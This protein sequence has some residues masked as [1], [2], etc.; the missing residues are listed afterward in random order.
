M[1]H[2]T[3]CEGARRPRTGNRGVKSLAERDANDAIAR[4]AEH[5]RTP[6][7]GGAYALILS[8]VAT[9][10]LGI[11]YWTLA[12]R[13][14]DPAQVGVNAAAISTMTFLSYLTQLNLAG[15]LSRFIPTA[16]RSTSRLVGAAYLLVVV[17]S[18]FAAFVFLAGLGLWAPQEHGLASDPLVAL[19][20]VVATMGWSLFALQDGVLTG[21]RQTVWVPIENT[22]FAVAKIVLLAAFALSL[23]EYGIFASWTIPAV[24][25]IIPVNLLI[26]RRFIPRHQSVERP[27][28][29]EVA[30]RRMLQYLTGDYLG[31]LAISA[32][33]ALLPLLVLIK[34]GPS[35]SAYFYIAWTI[36]YSLQL[37]SI[38]VATSLMVEG[39]AQRDSVAH[40]ARRML[41]LLIRL[42]V[43]IVAGVL[44][45]TPV[46]LRFFGAAYASEGEG[47]LRLLALAVLPHGVNAIYLSLARVRRRASRVAMVQ[48]TVSGLTLVLS[49]ILLGPM[50][51][52]GVGIAWLVAQSA[53]AAFLLATQLRPIWRGTGSTPSPAAAVGGDALP[54]QEG[55]AAGDAATDG[56]VVTQARREPPPALLRSAFAAFDAAGIGWTV[57]RGEEQLGS[58]G[59][60]IDLLVDAARS[61]EID[62]EL[63]RLGFVRLPSFGRGTHR[64]YIALEVESGHWTSLDLVSELAYGRL[65]ELAVPTAA[66]CLDR[67]HRPADV[68]VLEAGD[69][70]WT[71]LLH[72]ILDK[73]AVSE[74]RARRLFELER[75]ISEDSPTGRFAA[76]LLPAG[77]DSGRVRAAVRARDWPALLDLRGPL[78][79]A[80]L[81]RAPEDVLLRSV[82]GLALRV[83][84]PILKLRRRGLSVAV[85]GPDGAGKSTLAAGIKETFGLPVRLIYMGLWKTSDRHVSSWWRPL[86]IGLRPLAVWR[87]YLVAQTHRA[88]GRIVIFD[89]YTYDAFIPP[90][91]RFQGLKR[92]YF[93]ILARMIPE[94]DLVIV[95]DAPGVALFERKGESDP[96]S[97]E[98]D[99]AQFLALR[100]RVRRLEVIDARASADVVLSDA[101]QRIWD[102]YREVCG[103]RATI[104]AGSAT[105]ARSIAIAD[106]SSER[107]EQR[108]LRPIAGARRRLQRRTYGARGTR[109]VPAIL[110]HLRDQELV[111]DRP[112]RIGR[113][114]STETGVALITVTV[115][116]APSFLLKVPQ[117]ADA[118]RALVG[119]HELV[120]QLRGD[121]RLAGW[122]DLIPLVTAA[123]EVEGNAFL[124]EEM[125][126]GVAGTT[127]LGSGTARATMLL[128]AASAIRQLHRRTGEV[129]VVDDVLLESWVRKPLAAVERVLVDRFRAQGAGL[130]L[131]ELGRELEDQLAGQEVFTSWVHGDFWPG[132]VLLQPDGGKVTGIVDWDLAAPHQLPL[133][134][135]LHLILY[136]RR[137][138]YGRE[139]GDVVRAAIDDPRWDAT[140]RRLIDEQTDDTPGPQLSDRSAILLAWLRHVS[141]FSSV[142]GH[143]A[144][145]VWIRNNIETIIRTP[146]PMR[147]YG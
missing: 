119:H 146:R 44:I 41:S 73:R 97:L 122:S 111:E 133:H 88:L 24:L 40:D 131:A 89:R 72:S 28:E 56:S 63:V 33:T 113:V 84:E 30:P 132:N 2:G 4:L 32:S 55:S 102:T 17:L 87:R 143:G 57:L 21:L 123:G 46:V 137:V 54:V 107:V 100:N 16:G 74:A 108:I 22:I 51:I 69:E 34:V 112:W 83:M 3:P 90:S 7:Y 1:A 94:P 147:G 144:N 11:V 47:L 31:S 52:T 71:L 92:A 139:L 35:A 105:S 127:F 81:R 65:F 116:S 91:G 75:S 96:F 77:W 101:S 53:V 79:R 82:R 140:E 26:F 68:N 27:T 9:S 66:S 19:W 118:R 85:L 110:A 129:C 49:V 61:A 23:A 95:L 99:R 48:G 104:A 130:L 142:A 109:V 20:F 80:S 37:I 10:A 134:D 117:T 103:S 106:R 59:G 38:N 15:A 93:W 145:A 8:S 128:S 43:P 45:L 78:Q 25:S 64:F 120:S 121:P 98:A 86:E 58:A 12:A 6:L 115:E 138:R 50:G 114:H 5:V 14:Y 29:G 76:S 125:L 18:G 67:R 124:V 42:Q 13:L 62:A 135:V 39:A 126:P 36:A 60:D 141:I 136:S 70:F